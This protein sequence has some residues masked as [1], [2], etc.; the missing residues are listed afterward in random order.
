MMDLRELTRRFTRPGRLEAIF[1]RPQRGVPATSLDWVLAETGQGLVGDRS[2]SMRRSVPSGTSKRQVTLMQA[3]HLQVVANWLGRQR[4]DPA[5]LRRN[6]VVSGFNL[7]AA[8]S[9]F[10]GQVLHVRLGNE[11]VLQI[12]G[13]CDPCSKMEATLGAGAYN[14]LRGHGGVTARVLSGGRLAVGDLV[15]VELPAAENPSDPTT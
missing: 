5:L 10:S 9:P 6:L 2:S 7:L 15:Q 13:P 4:L 11:V 3:E 14:A 1:V 8:R 12:T